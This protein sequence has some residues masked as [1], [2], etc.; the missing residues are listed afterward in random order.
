MGDADQGKSLD[1]VLSFQNLV[2]FGIASIMGSGGFNLI[3]DAVIAGG[4]QFPIALAAIAALFQGTSL[5][6]QEA[7]NEF[8]TNTSESDLIE[9]EFGPIASNISSA[10]ILA[11][12]L[13]STSVVI[14]ICAKLLFPS[15]SWS[16]QIS[17]AMLLLSGITVTALKGIELNKY[18]IT[19][20]GLL[21]AILLGFASM[22]GFIEL[23]AYG[24]PSKLPTSLDVK[25]SLVHSI[26]YFYFVLAGFDTLMKFAEE[27]KDPDND[28]ARSFYA[29]NAISTLLTIGVC[30]AFLMSFTTHRFAENE[31][32]VSRIVG[33]MLGPTAEQFTFVV[34]IV[35][36]I[37]T[38]F[39]C[40]LASTRYMFSLASQHSFA[41]L[42][43]LNNDKAPWKA[44]LLS[45]VVVFLGVFSNN[46]YDLV[47]FSDIALT[48]TL[49][50]VS[51]AATRMQDAKGK[52]PWIEGMTTT[53]LGALLSACIM[54]R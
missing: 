1:R 40:F 15:G 37:V 50:L 45:A 33:V 36:M 17:F 42:R 38:G 8:K 41:S 25:P 19:I 28:L 14:V 12:N 39:V 13:I 2:G 22:I 49:L 27:T 5:T 18:I 43:E 44:I 3:G 16:G 54:Y 31:N 34:S 35:L 53:G 11:F 7:Y 32:V 48:I 26:L 51:A 24:L 52:T 9:K 23:G 4:H 47:K 21:V 6:Y 30:F 10:A 20:A 46:V 29:S